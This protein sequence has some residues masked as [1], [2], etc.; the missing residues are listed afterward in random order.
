MILFGH[1]GIGSFLAKP[2]G[3][4]LPRSWLL[5]GTVFPDLLDK[6]LYY[7]LK[8]VTGK[9]GTE[10]GLIS[11]TRTFGHTAL[12]LLCI[13]GIASWKKSRNLAALA[14]GI[15]TH[16]LLDGGVD[17]YGRYLGHSTTSALF[18]PFVTSRFP[19][20]PHSGVQGHFVNPATP[21]LSAAEILGLALLLWERKR[22]K[23]GRRSKAARSKDV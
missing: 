23:A 8:L 16:L 6:P 11:G 13:A 22:E 1:L 9:S 14:L 7:S 4:G 3:R 17:M 10:L 18:W 5:M 21:L 2:L 15:S 20:F 19:V 12:L